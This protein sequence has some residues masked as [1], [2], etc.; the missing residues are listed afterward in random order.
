MRVVI[1][2]LLLVFIANTKLVGQ[3]VTSVSPLLRE[4]STDSLDKYI[5][6]GISNKLTVSSDHYLFFQI[7]ISEQGIRDVV[8][9][10]SAHGTI[11][12][13]TADAIKATDRRWYRPEKG[14]LNIVIPVFL[15]VEKTAKN[16]SD[17]PIYHK[18]FMR[19]RTPINCILFPPIVF[20]YYA[21]SHGK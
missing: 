20:T 6:K 15:I 13:I 9:L 11:S 12:N 17:E 16:A 14:E 2:G 18:A 3:H 5:Y 10:Y 8:E 1:L 7:T 4:G 21:P 19:N